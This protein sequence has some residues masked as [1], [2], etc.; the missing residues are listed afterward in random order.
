MVF[1]TSKISFFLLTIVTIPLVFN[2]DFILSLWLKTVPLYSGVFCILTLCN[3]ILNAL[4][5]PLN[6]AVMATGRIKWFQ[7]VTSIV[8]ISDLFILYALFAMGFPPATALVVK[9]IIMVFV[10]FVRLHFAH[11][12]VPCIDLTSYTKSIIG[13]LSVSSL[14]SIAAAFVLMNFASTPIEKICATCGMIAISFFFAY[15]IGLSSQERLSLKGVI[16]KML[17][18]GK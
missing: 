9:V 14:L 2:I 18:K 1:S 11:I 7:I 15:F 3:G 17:K 8:Y 5:A 6:F 13:P 10:L 16:N 4:S 12:N